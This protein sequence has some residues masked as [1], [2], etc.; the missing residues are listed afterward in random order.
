MEFFYLIKDM[1][2]LC[3]SWFYNFMLFYPV[4]NFPVQ[5]GKNLLHLVFLFII[6][7]RE[8]FHKPHLERLELTQK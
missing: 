8:K 2:L 4:G 5:L 6:L 3:Y 1:L 7:H